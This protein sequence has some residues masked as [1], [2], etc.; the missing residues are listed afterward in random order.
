MLICIWL[1]FFYRGVYLEISDFLLQTSNHGSWSSWGPW[2]SCSRTCGGGVQFAN[3]LCNNPPPRNNG[4]YCTGKRA[5]YRSCNVSPCPPAG[6]ISQQNRTEHQHITA[7]QS[8]TAKPFH[9]TAKSRHNNISQQ[10]HFTWKFVCQQNILRQN[11]Y[12]TIQYSILSLGEIC[13]GLSE[14]CISKSHVSNENVCK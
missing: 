13:L 6:E 14:C 7:L 8:L 10:N 12:N 1:M 9:I 2:G 11:Q 4:R 3:R 5:V